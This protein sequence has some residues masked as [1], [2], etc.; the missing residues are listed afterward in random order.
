Y[1]A[2]LSGAMQDQALDDAAINEA[3][4][5]LPPVPVG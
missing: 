5:A 1:D 4:G 2:Y 3:I